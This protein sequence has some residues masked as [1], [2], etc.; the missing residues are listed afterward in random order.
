MAASEEYRSRRNHWLQRRQESERLFIR[1]GNARLVLGITEGILAYLVFGPGRVPAFS[2]AI[3]VV[4]FIV[5]AVWQSRVVRERTLADRA[6]SFYDRGLARLDDKWVGS[7]SSGE[8]FRDGS[9]VYADDLDLFGKGSLFELIAETRTAAAEQML[10]SWLLASATYAEALERQA[11]VKELR[12]GV[13]LREHFGLLGPDIQA[14]VSVE[15]V[16]KWGESPIVH[17]PSVLRPVFAVFAC[18]SVA[19]LVAF[20]AGQ[21]SPVPLVAAVAI[22]V[23]IGFALRSKVQPVLNHLDAVSHGLPILSLAFA[24]LERESFE[25]PLL[26]R[27]MSELLAEHTPASVR[28]RQLARWVD[29]HDSADH[30]L[31]RA[32]RPLLFWGEQIAMG[33]ERWRRQSGPR[34]ASWLRA[35]AEFEALSSL[36]ALSFERPGWSFPEL[37]PGAV[38][39]FSAEDLKH[40]LLPQARAVGNDASLG[41]E[42]RLLIVSGSNMSG[43][44]TFL[45]AIGLNTALAWAGGPVCARSMQVSCLHLGASIRV[46]DSVLDNRSRFFA[47]IVRIKQI[48]DLAKSSQTALFLL[49]ELLSG[50][51]SHDRQIGAAAIVRKL[52]EFGAIGVIT[53]HD[54]ALAHIQDELNGCAANAHFDDQILNGEITF[55]YRLRP[56]I[57]THSN[58]LELMRSVGLDV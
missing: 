42:L 37:L 53:T 51:N 34:V 25:A 56:G 52:V 12:D 6:L 58:A 10:A 9:H 35:L 3:P 24:R 29:W 16:A 36:A 11:A 39:T 31:I 22:D 4:L 40:P 38:A 50:T 13:G 49:D 44:S 19:L 45:R 28:V 17:F 55:D 20:F 8:R 7:G 32:L 48:V 2:L 15:A 5:L 21:I 57:V 27:L 1:I 54:L 30:A 14:E 43:K 23:S 47:E 26:Q 46:T 18:I 33:V 41:Q